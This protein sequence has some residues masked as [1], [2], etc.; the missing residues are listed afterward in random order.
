MDDSLPSENP[1]FESNTS[2]KSGGWKKVKE[3]V[4]T[5]TKKSNTAQTNTGTTATKT[6]NPSSHEEETKKDEEELNVQI[7]EDNEQFNRQNFDN[8]SKHFH[9]KS[10]PSEEGEEEDRQ[11]PHGL[12]QRRRSSG[13][14]RQSLDGDGKGS[15][16]RRVS[17]TSAETKA[18]LLAKVGFG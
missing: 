4:M 5:Y 14:S 1:T 13:T 15:D 17:V 12:R 6:P 10:T 7:I 16:M 3:K 9:S 18:A 8:L 11:S 2:K